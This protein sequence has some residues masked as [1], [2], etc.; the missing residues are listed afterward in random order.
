MFSLF[1][2]EI[3]AKLGI[4]APRIL[5]TTMYEQ[6]FGMLRKYADLA[7]S[8]RSAVFVQ[9]IVVLSGTGLLVSNSMFP[10]AMFSA[11]FCLIMTFML[12]NMHTHYNNYFFSVRQYIEYLEKRYSLDPFT[13][14]VSFVEAKRDERVKFKRFGW[15]RNYGPFVL[16]GCSALVA[17]FLIGLLWFN[18]DEPNSPPL[19]QLV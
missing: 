12:N 10:W 13:G 14:Y 4:P 7:V 5:P 8:M 11:F 17:M 2:R 18:M 19:F 6:A 1:E 15:M 16:I 3:E 9:G